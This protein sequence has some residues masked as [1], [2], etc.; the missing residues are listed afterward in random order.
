M[1]NINMLAYD[2]GASSGRAII[3]SFD[4]DK[5]RL[6]EI[7][8]FSNDPVYVRGHLYWDVLR[9]LHE[10]KQGMLKAKKYKNISSLGIDTWG[11]DFGLLDSHGDLMG[12][13]YDY[14]DSMT[15]GMMEKAFSIIP[16]KEIFEHTGI[17]FL[18]F[19]TIYQLYALASYNPSL[20]DRAETLLMMPDLMNYFLTGRKSTEYT[21]SST[22]QLYDSVKSGWSFNLMSKLGIPERLFTNVIPAG[23]ILSNL[24]HDISEETGLNSIPVVSV[25]SHDTGS[26]VASVPAD[27][28]D[29]VYISCGT[30]SLMGMETEKPIINDLSL[31]YNFTNEGGVNGRIRFLRNI[32]GLWLLQESRRQWEREGKKYTFDE[33]GDLAMQAVPLR[34]L[35]DPDAPEFIS[36]G[37]IP[38][39]IREYAKA[40]NMYV[41]K[42]IGEVVRCILES[43]AMKYRQTV[44]LL[45]KIVLNGRKV[46]VIHI[47]GGGTKDVNLCQ[48]TADATGKIVMAG[49]VEATAIGNLLVQAMA[50]GHISD[51]AQLRQVVKNSFPIKIYEPKNTSAW[52]E[53]Y[54]KI[55][56]MHP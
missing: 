13:P 32:A 14:R 7:H 31:K 1:N 19:N 29:F 18:R 42:T 27:E 28:K 36:P 12:N 21:I 6:E 39:R 25:A 15:D 38:G 56:E 35:I 22:T 16:Q 46:K 53:A 54:S 43:L 9:L 10:I 23:S 40:N 48:L 5:L 8:R 45:E 17:Q 30:W 52:N 20:L 26:A 47:L 4:G 33:L 34:T 51:L 44:E 37:D 24:S 55:S 41:P 49:P 2:F 50:L 11:V 3:G